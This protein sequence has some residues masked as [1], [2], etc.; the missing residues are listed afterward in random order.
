MRWRMGQ[1]V[2]DE[3]WENTLWCLCNDYDEYLQFAKDL[4][5]Y[6]GLDIWGTMCENE[7]WIDNE[8]EWSDLFGVDINEWE[9]D[10]TGE[11]FEKPVD[12]INDVYEMKE[13]PNEDEY[14]VVV[15][16]DNYHKNVLW[17]SLDKL[18]GKRE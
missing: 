16:Y 10:E 13:K 1:I 15:H 5:L 11:Y 18:K 6:K 7:K 3:R 12:P 4:Y 14:P 2:R 8:Y 17:M 9:D